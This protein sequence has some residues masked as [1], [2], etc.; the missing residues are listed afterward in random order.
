MLRVGLENPIL[1]PFLYH[2]INVKLTRDKGTFDASVQYEK[3]HIFH[4]RVPSKNGHKTEMVG[5]VSKRGPIVRI[6]E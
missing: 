4:I 1:K 6:E 2:H 5:L 3:R